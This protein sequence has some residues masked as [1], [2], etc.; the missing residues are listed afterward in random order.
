MG[1]RRRATAGVGHAA[2][3]QTVRRQRTM[4]IPADLLSRDDDWQ[5][6]LDSVELAQEHAH[7]RT[8]I[9]FDLPAWQSLLPALDFHLIVLGSFL[10]CAEICGSVVDTAGDFAD[11]LDMVKSAFRTFGCETAAMLM[12]DAVALDARIVARTDEYYD[13]TPELEAE[14]E[15]LNTE[16]D[17]DTGYEKLA[18]FIRDHA[19][20]LLE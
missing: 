5:V 6:F 16:I 13:I 19:H 15:R 12:D 4:A 1:E 11:K 14:R 3:A 18:A 17:A 8:G 20:E 7:K 9:D 2:D 10:G